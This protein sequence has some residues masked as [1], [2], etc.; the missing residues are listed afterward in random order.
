MQKGQN[1][2]ARRRGEFDFEFELENTKNT[3]H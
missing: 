3:L 1:L 2:N